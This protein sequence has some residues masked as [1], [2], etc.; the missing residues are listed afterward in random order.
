[1]CC[2]LVIRA[3]TQPL[4]NLPAMFPFLCDDFF[5]WNLYKSS[6]LP[7]TWRVD[8]RARAKLSTEQRAKRRL[9]S[10]GKC[11]AGFK[12]PVRVQAITETIVCSWVIYVILALELNCR[13]RYTEVITFKTIIRFGNC[14]NTLPWIQNSIY[15]IKQHFIQPFFTYGER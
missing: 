12:A 15:L 8:S 11:L 4:C 2:C 3:A 5:P 10:D 7:V 13:P 9:L 6:L 14:S 1:M